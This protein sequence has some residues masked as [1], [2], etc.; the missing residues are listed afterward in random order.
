MSP[1]CVDISELFSELQLTS[2]DDPAATADIEQRIA[3]LRHSLEQLPPKM[4]A[5]LLLHRYAGFS[6]EEIG[7]RLGVSRPTAKKYLARAL[8]HCRAAETAAE[9]SR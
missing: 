1:K 9:G 4:S 8:S 3:Q 7:K 6:I 5:T 2:N